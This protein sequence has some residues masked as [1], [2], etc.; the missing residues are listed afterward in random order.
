MKA[1]ELRERTDEDLRDE[2]QGLSREL[3]NMRF[4]WQTEESSN[5]AQYAKLRRSIAQINTILH[6]RELGRNAD[7]DQHQNPAAPAA[8]PVAE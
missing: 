2:L 1:S 6:E 8:E 4:Q 3:F 7:I 5:P